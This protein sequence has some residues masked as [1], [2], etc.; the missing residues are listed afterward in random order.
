MALLSDNTNETLA[1][2]CTLPEQ[3]TQRPRPGSSQAEPQQPHPRRWMETSHRPR[4]APATAQW[5]P[6]PALGRPLLLYAVPA[7]ISM[8]SAGKKSLAF[9]P[10]QRKQ[11][12]IYTS[13]APDTKTPQDTKRLRN[14]AALRTSD[15]SGLRNLTQRRL[16]A[17]GRRRG[18]LEP[19]APTKGAHGWKGKDATE[20]PVCYH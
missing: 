15:V 7:W 12:K 20:V 10:L 1:A 11:A 9:V 8:W 16:I 5:R 2:T 3:S 18:R 6:P 14:S 13:T 4:L 17:A 19:T